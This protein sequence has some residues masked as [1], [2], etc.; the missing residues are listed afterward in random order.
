MFVGVARPIFANVVVESLRLG[1][2]GRRALTGVSR[3][4][5]RLV[6]CSVNP[7]TG[8]PRQW[9]SWVFASPIQDEKRQLLGPFTNEV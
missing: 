8:V 6:S 3:A 1:G 7:T 9:V 2:P 4:L 5:L